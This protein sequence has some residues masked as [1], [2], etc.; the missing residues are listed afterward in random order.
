MQKLQ[1]LFIL[2][3]L[4]ILLWVSAY[5]VIPLIVKLFGGKFLE[6]A[7]H[8]IYIFFIGIVLLPSLLGC[9]FN[10]CFNSDFYTKTKK[11]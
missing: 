10:D 5:C 11:R 7:Q 1:R 9:V 6:I 8:P 2:A 3:V 4:F